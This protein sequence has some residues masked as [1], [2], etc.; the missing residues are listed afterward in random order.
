M[1]DVPSHITPQST[2]T[3]TDGENTHTHTLS[4]TSEDNTECAPAGEQ[5]DFNVL[6]LSLFLIKIIPFSPI[7]RKR[8]CLDRQAEKGARRLDRSLLV[9][10][11]ITFNMALV[12]NVMQSD[13][14][15]AGA[16]LSGERRAHVAKVTSGLLGGRA[17]LHQST[18]SCDWLTEQ[19]HREKGP[20]REENLDKS[21]QQ[22][23]QR[24]P[25][26]PVR[27]GYPAGTSP[28]V[29]SRESLLVR[30]LSDGNRNLFLGNQISSLFPFHLAPGELY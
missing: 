28:E 26:S 18:F 14:R 9:L 8:F 5:K 25:G 11:W 2:S 24:R 30:L 23:K 20:T 19:T 3:N 21:R 22:L 7:H 12:W 6:S 16:Q 1:Q 10:F 15:E 13:S 27:P 17:G 29:N 4:R